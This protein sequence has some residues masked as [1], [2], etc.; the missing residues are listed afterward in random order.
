VAL[1]LS[2]FAVTTLRCTTGELTGLFLEL[3]DPFVEMPQPFGTFGI[4]PRGVSWYL[5][6]R[7]DMPAVYLAGPS[8]LVAELE[9]AFPKRLIRL[10]LEDRYY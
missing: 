2:S 4:F 9:Q 7:D 1:T 5:H 6:H 10:M 8:A 3:T